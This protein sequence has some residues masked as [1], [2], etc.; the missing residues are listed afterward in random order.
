[1]HNADVIFEWKIHPLRDHPRRAALFFLTLGVTLIA[2]WWSFRNVGW[3]LMAALLVGGSL[4]RFWLVTDYRISEQE[5]E[6]R[7]LFVPMTRRWSDFRRVVFDA[8]GA[9]LSPFAQANRLEQYRGIYLPYPPDPE[10]LK[11]F[12]ERRFAGD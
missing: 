1:M 8:H 10:P 4:H 6:Y 11:T 12:L 3:V 7:R 9:F 5:L 2:V